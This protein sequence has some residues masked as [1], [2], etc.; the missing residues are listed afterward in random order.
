M[1]VLVNGLGNIGSTICSMLLRYQSILGIE[2]IYAHKNLP[3]PWGKAELERWQ[4][5]GVILCSKASDYPDLENHISEI[6]YIFDC[7]ANGFGLKN[8]AFYEQLPQ[9]KGA[10]AQGS[11]KGFGLPFM[12]GI[13]Q[14]YINGA[15]FVQVVSCNTHG[16][17]ALLKT[18]AG[19][20]LENLVKADFV[21]VRRSEDLGHHRRLVS[22]NVVARH[23]H[24]AIGTHHAI[25]VT[26][27]FKAI[28]IDCEISSSDITTP[29]QLMHAVRFNIELKSP[30]QGELSELITKQAMVAVTEKFDSNVVFEQG[31]RHGFLGRIYEHIILVHNNFLIQDRQ[32]RGWAFVPQ[33][34][35]TILSTLHAFLLQMEVETAE[36]IMEKLREEL[37]FG[38]W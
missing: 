18:F 7:T 29:A 1:K 38:V 8:K 16:S 33:E 25:D 9:L 37:V 14:N 19:D 17:A 2:Q 22:A 26:D 12:S 35:N 23:L 13:A 10:V 15:K 34:G 36:K 31:R 5:Q 32:L 30:L 21:V 20:Q 4:K 27:M 28:G 3:S 6:D 24:P 11:E